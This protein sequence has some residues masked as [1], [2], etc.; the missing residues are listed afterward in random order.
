MKELVIGAN[1]GTIAAVS[2]CNCSCVAFLSTASTAI[3]LT[4]STANGCTRSAL[5][6]L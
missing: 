1:I 2:A 3:L 5:S 6:R 4:V